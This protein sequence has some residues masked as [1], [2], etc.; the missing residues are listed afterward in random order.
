MRIYILSLIFILF[1]QI[2][3]GI[4]S[5]LDMELWTGEGKSEEEK[6]KA[7][8]CI[9]RDLKD[10]GRGNPYGTAISTINKVLK[11]IFTPIIHDV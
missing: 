6:N 3:D 11:V 5:N 9:I 7:L 4:P 8:G 10:Y 1:F 2:S